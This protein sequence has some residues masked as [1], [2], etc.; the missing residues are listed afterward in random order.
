MAEKGLKPLPESFPMPE[1]VRLAMEG[2]KKGKR[3]PYERFCAAGGR[4]FGPLVR[5]RRITEK[6]RREIREAGLLLE[7]EEWLG[8]TLLAALA[9]AIACVV[10]WISMGI[11]GL[12][13]LSLL[14]MPVAGILLG[15]FSMIAFQ[16]Y[17]S[18]LAASR[19]ADA[20]G[21]AIPTIM[22]LSFSLYHRPDLRGAVV[23]AADSTDGK[24]AEDLRRGLLE[25]DEKRKHDTVRH[26][27]TVTANEWGRTDDSIRQAIFDIL[28]STGTKDESARVMDISR[29]PMRALEGMDEQLTRRL[30]SLIMPTL[31]FLTFSSLAIIAVI[32]LSPV[33]GIIGASALDIKFFILMCALLSLAFWTFTAYMARGRPATIQIPEPPPDD[34][35]LPPPG[36]CIIG[37]VKLP[38]WLPPLLVM[39][40][41]SV[42]GVIHVMGW[43]SGEIRMIAGS[44]NVV[45][46]VWAFSAAVAL[47]GY[48]YFSPRRRVQE[49]ERK[50][51]ADW[52]NALNTMGSRMLD[53]KPISSAMTEA[54]EMMEGSPLAEQLKSAGAKMERYGMGLMDALFGRSRRSGMVESFLSTISRIRSDSEL[55]AGRAC[56]VAAEFLR[57]LHRVERNFRERIGEALSNLWLV[58]VL[59]IPVVCAMSV[60]VMDYMTGLSLKIAAQASAAGVTGIP[61][62]FGVM[63]SGDLAI[64]RLLMGLTTVVL[65]IIV[66]RYISRIRAG[67]DRVEMWAS[68]A[69]SSLLSAA[70]F[71]A[72]S[73]LLTLITVGM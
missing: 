5:G 12:D 34:P 24:L 46:F 17:P 37:G 62:L 25:M 43:G 33:F 4:I 47:Y 72:T 66:A 65:G 15:G 45:W 10:L 26:L 53:G 57:T 13:L 59:L 19:R 56:M 28:R 55:A 71:T 60:W 7:P 31:A 48:L 49:E 39:L 41:L 8:G 52:G 50:R 73:Y 18:S 67:S 14:Y 63:G 42:P 68:V 35:R 21:K 38:I 6:S 22:V 40:A 61:L 51:I 29:A 9:P 16:A 70:V 44:L 2:L 11:L 1:D 54:G 23:Q 3:T 36:R 20:Q 32:G 58:A 69:R 30:G 27:L 64:L